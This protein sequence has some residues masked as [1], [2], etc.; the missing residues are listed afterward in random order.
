MVTNWTTPNK[1]TTTTLVICAKCFVVLLNLFV[2][3]Y[4]MKEY[5]LDTLT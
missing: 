3:T 5:H 4:F 1:K 2:A